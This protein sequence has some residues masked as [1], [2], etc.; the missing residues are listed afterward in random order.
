MERLLDVN[1]AEYDHTHP[2]ICIDEASKQIIADV[3]PALPLSPG[4][5]RREDHHYQRQEVQAL[6]MFFDPLRG[7]RRVSTRATRLG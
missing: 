1:Q 6:F 7:W 4:Q 3:E 2:L 5:P